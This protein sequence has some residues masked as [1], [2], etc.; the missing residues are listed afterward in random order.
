MRM[1]EMRDFFDKYLEDNG[2]LK[3]DSRAWSAHI[4]KVPMISNTRKTPQGLPVFFFE[5]EKALME[6]YPDASR[7][8]II[9]AWNT[10]E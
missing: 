8:E 6:K 3:G 9:N 4:R 7:E 10:N 2:T 1:V 5:F